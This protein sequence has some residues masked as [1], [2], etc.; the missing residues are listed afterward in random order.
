MLITQCDTELGCGNYYDSSLTECDKCGGSTVLLGGLAQC[1]YRYIVWDLETYPNFFSG[2]FYSPSTDTTWTFEIS[3]RKNDA[4]RLVK[5]IYQLQYSNSILIGYNS[6]GFDY[7]VLHEIMK[8][9]STDITVAQIYNKAMLIINNPRCSWNPHVVWENQWI[10]KQLDLFKI[11]GYDNKARSTSLK[12]LEV[13]MKMESVQELPIEPGTILTSEQMDQMLP[14]NKHD[15]LATGLFLL[16]H[17]QSMIAFRTQLNEKFP[18]VSFSNLADIK[19]G[20][21]IFKVKLNEGGINT[22]SEVNGRKQALS[23]PREKVELKGCIPEWINFER[24]EFSAILKRF[25][26][27]TLIGTNV[28]ALFNKFSCTIDGAEYIF[29]GGGLHMAKQGVFE[30]TDIK[31][32]KDLDIEAYY[33]SLI[34][35]NGIYPEHLGKG[36]SKIYQWLI[37]ERKKAGKKTQEGMAYKLG[38]NSVFGNLA[39]EYS[40]VY[41]IKAL[42]SVTLTGQLSICMLIEQLLKIP[43]LEMFYVNT[44]GFTLMVDKI[45]D[46]HLKE[47][48]T[49]WEN[50]TNLK[51]EYANYDKILV[52]DVNNFIAVYE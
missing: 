33:P 20:L 48:V 45:Y 26:E 24:P 11:N 28:K 46:K 2:I 35:A 49:W 30:S 32:I 31:E 16:N 23:T 5:F 21:E 29:G 42:L 43:G 9:G 44:D 7:P 19:I 14:Y 27:T 39:N 41:D 17:C 40:Y 22:H 3:D 13:A 1:D 12:A 47:V 6:L 4:E 10:V 34:L 37:D 38:S 52:N 8:V 15:V 18:S 51:M 25:K 50:M 36:F